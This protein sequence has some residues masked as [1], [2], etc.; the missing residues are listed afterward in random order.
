MLVSVMIHYKCESRAYQVFWAVG[1]LKLEVEVGYQ[2]VFLKTEL[3][4]V[5]VLEHSFFPGVLEC[6]FHLQS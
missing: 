2:R 3:D 5:S 6:D 1:K 4:S